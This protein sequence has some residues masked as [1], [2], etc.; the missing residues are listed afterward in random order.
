MSEGG[1]PL[2]TNM[3]LHR[4]SHIHC[5]SPQSHVGKPQISTHKNYK[6]VLPHSTSLST[7]NSASLRFHSEP[8]QKPASYNQLRPSQQKPPSTSLTHSS[9]TP[10]FSS[11][12]DQPK[13]APSTN[14]SLRSR[15]PDMRRSHSVF[16]VLALYMAYGHE[17][18][19]QW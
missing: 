6:H 16:C 1:R 19:A 7:P 15:D 11:T 17:E 10:P 12:T 14:P 5:L 2:R 9:R 18:A 13:H 8:L 3:S 4:M